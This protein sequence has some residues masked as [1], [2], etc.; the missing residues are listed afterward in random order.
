MKYMIA[1]ICVYAWNAA[2][3][4]EKAQASLSLSTD[5]SLNMK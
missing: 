1:C 3:C 2:I 4:R 5:S